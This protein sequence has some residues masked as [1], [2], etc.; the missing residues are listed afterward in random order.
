MEGQR[1]RE[2]GREGERS[3]QGERDRELWS[4]EVRGL[5]REDADKKQTEGAHK[6]DAKKKKMREDEKRR[7]RVRTARHGQRDMKREETR[8]RVWVVQWVSGALCCRWSRPIMSNDRPWTSLSCYSLI[9]FHPCLPPTN[10][11][12][13]SSHV[14]AGRERMYSPITSEQRS[15]KWCWYFP[16]H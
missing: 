9:A 4:D 16:A 7:E 8:I 13:M 6:K 15:A 11:P 5:R 14:I 1:R 10:I 3:V 2:R 12:P